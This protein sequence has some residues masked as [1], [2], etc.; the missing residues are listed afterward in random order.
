M[1]AQILTAVNSLHAKIDTS[2]DQL[3]RRMNGIEKETNGV[4]LE[5]TELKAS[6]PCQELKDHLENHDASTKW[7]TS[8][9]IKWVL[10]VCAIVAGA[11][12]VAWFGWG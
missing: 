5:L 1:S 9:I 4:K 6:K 8:E 2:T 10:L 12:L 11:G 7:W 3:H